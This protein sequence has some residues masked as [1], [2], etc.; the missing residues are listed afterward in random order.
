M[1]SLHP[2]PRLHTGCSLL[3][4]GAMCGRP[5]IGLAAA[6]A[7]EA[8]QWLRLRWNFDDDACSRAWQLTSILTA[9]VAVMLLVEGTRLTALPELLSWLPALM[10]PV[11]F[12][13]SYGMRQGIPLSSISYFARRQKQRALRLGLPWETREFHFGNVTFFLCLV[14]ATVGK[15]SQS[16]MFLAGLLVLIG[17]RV[18]G[19]GK[20]RASV[21]LPVLA[22]CGLG[23]LVG[24]FSI[25][26]MEERFGWRGSS[27]QNRFNPS[28]NST[29]IGTVGEVTLSPE[30]EW[31]LRPVQGPPP[32][33]LRTASYSFFQGSTWQAPKVPERDFVGLENEIINEETLYLAYRPERPDAEAPS[34]FEPQSIVSRPVFTLRGAANDGDPLPLPGDVSGISQIEVEAIECNSYGTIRINPKEPVINGNVYWRG[35]THPEPP[36]GA[37]ESFRIP[38]DERETVRAIAREIGIQDGAGDIPGTLARLKTWF[39]HEFRYSLQLDISRRTTK[40]DETGPI[41]RFLTTQRSGH[42]EYFATAAVMLLREAGIPAR[43][44][45]GFAVVEPRPDRKEFVI[46]G[47]HSHAWC[48]VWDGRRWIDFDPTP[49]DWTAVGFPKPTLSQRFEDFMKCVR[50]D[51]FV[52]RA[53]PTNQLIITLVMSGIGCALGSVVVVKL[54]RS[55]SVVSNTPAGAIPA[56]PQQGRT[57]FHD[58]EPLIRRRGGKRL[59][60]EPYPQWAKR[61][62]QPYAEGAMIDEAV[63]LHQKLRFDPQ[64][65]PPG[66]R[67]RLEELARG[68]RNALRTP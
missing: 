62:L 20:C 14:A 27:K 34:G 7:T 58:L 67:E 57:P 17:W 50:E 61:I 4:W 23:A 44:A 41:S 28:Y 6:L 40:G 68:L 54:W 29:L 11:Q 21:L 8:H 36:P 9:M 15:E 63:T 47:T 48:R 3:F 30:I 18:L 5:L 60:G 22:L 55:R 38:T 35:D 37:R 45:T 46:R 39:F 32:S 64:S 13:Q 66:L 31:R 16:W 65:T 56:R 2:P 24:E 33:L 1:H 43:Y 10:L 26:K 12:V 25:R 52:W 53:N 19:D 59:P 42:C 51:F 49:S